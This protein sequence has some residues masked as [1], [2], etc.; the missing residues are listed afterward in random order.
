MKCRGKRSDISALKQFLRFEEIGR[1]PLVGNLSTFTDTDVN[2]GVQ[3]Y[4]YRTQ[5]IDSC[6]YA[7][8]NGNQA[9]SILLQGIADEIQQ[10]NYVYW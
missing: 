6:G 9:T 3:S 5:Y 4:T 1:S 10:I 2:V 7:G 8:S